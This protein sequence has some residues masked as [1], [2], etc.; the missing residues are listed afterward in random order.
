VFTGEYRHTVDEKGRIAIPARFRVELAQGAHVT[1]WIDGCLALFPRA[2]WEILAE[3]TA[4]LPVTNPDAR[5]F[6]RLLFGSAF[7]VEPDRQGR[8]VLP[9]AL[10]E[11]A[12]LG[13]DVVIV[14]LRNHLELWSP[15]Q[16]DQ[17]SQQMDQPEVLAEHLQGLGI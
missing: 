9:S 2:E 13:A 10:R 3:R 11:F 17:Y 6:R 5:T 4:G 7:E 15:Q 14:G 12:G 16:W 8:F 1:K